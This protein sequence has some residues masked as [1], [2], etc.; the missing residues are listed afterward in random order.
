MDL[1]IH[2][3]LPLTTENFIHRSGRAARGSWLGDT[4]SLV[5]Q[6]EQ[7][8]LQNLEQKLQIQFQ[9]YKTEKEE[10]V[11]KQMSK[12]DNLKRKVKVKFVSGEK[13]EKFNERKIQKR[14]F[15]KSLQQ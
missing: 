3:N 7:E 2:Y 13:F 6:Y 15:Q 8:L 5:T 14:N 11:L 1:V 10:T 9:E 12:I 4:I